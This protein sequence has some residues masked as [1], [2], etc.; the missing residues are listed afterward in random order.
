MTTKDSLDK[1]LEALYKTHPM[2]K[3]LF[4]KQLEV[5]LNPARFISVIT[6][7]RSGKTTMAAVH[8]IEDLSKNV[9]IG[10]YVARTDSSVR[11]IFMPIVKPL[12]RK[13]G[14]IA[15]VNADEIVFSNGSKLLVLGANHPHKIENFR[16]LKLRFAIVDECASFNQ[17]ILVY[18]IN[19]ILIRRLSDLQGK[20]FL[21]GTPA[22]HCS[23][24]FYEVT[25]GLEIGWAKHHWTAFD[26]PH[27]R[28]QSFTDIEFEMA[29]KQCDRN[30]PRLL[31]EYDGVWS[32]DDD[33]FLM[34]KPSLMLPPTH[35]TKERWRS[36]IGVDFGFND[37]TA[38]SVIG[39]ERDSNRAYV[40]ETFGITGES[41]QKSKLGM[42]TV[43]GKTLQELRGK[44]SPMRIVGDP[45]G[46]S[47]II[48]DEMQ[49][50]YKINI[51]PAIKKDKAHYIEIMNDAIT[52]Q[53]LV[54]HPTNTQG[55]QKEIAKLVWNEDHTREREGMK[56]DHFDAT[57][58]AW[59]EVMAHTEKLP[60]KVIWDERAN[61]K[62]FMEEVE[63]QDSISA[64]STH[65]EEDM[66][67]I[68]MFL[69]KQ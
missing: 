8:A 10:L 64:H 29:R 1:Q 21:I 69:S 9:G 59:R 25:T 5:L 57:L 63:R 28:Q 44:Y 42:V 39:W 61:E 34:K 36:I 11:D 15:K 56:C 22:A 32:T 43:I 7:S 20:L 53:L 65:E 51:E 54:F 24:L 58:Y 33:E 4:F 3:E 40:L 46:A 16:G 48:L 35:Y 62:Q 67:E 30:A 23:G 38:F 18:F 49:M 50:K 60:T 55:L 45:A 66:N 6:G 17:D 2:Y 52:N 26:N 27:V 19:D 68:G 13:Y 12:L 47:K 14:I 31:R 41:V 37:E